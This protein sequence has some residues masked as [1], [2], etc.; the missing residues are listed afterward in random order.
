MIF[1]IKTSE[2]DNPKTGIQGI[3]IDEELI[4]QP[5]EFS[6]LTI[7][8]TFGIT[9]LLSVATI[10]LKRFCEFILKEIPEVKK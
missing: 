1:K 7:I 2:L 10:D 3:E 5:E 6:N 9:K 8:E 4:N